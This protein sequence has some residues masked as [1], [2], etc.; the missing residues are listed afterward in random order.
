MLADDAAFR[1]AG[2]S[3]QSSAGWSY[4]PNPA[5][6][7]AQDLMGAL[8]RELSGDRALSGM[9]A[10]AMT[11]AADL[12]NRFDGTTSQRSVSGNVIIGKAS[13]RYRW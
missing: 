13:V 5:D 11:G 9:F 8:P 10:G 12:I 6:L 4:Q 7:T 3:M 2:L 1:A